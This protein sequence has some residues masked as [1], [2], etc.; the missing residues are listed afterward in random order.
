MKEE[1]R[2]E[3]SA[4]AVFP[5]RMKILPNCI[6]NKRDPIVVGI[7]IIE[8]TARI[9]TPICVPS[10]GKITI[11]KIASMEVDH[12]AV[13]KAEKGKSVAMKIAP[14][15]ADE[16]QRAIGRHFDH[17]DE[18]VSNIS[19]RSIDLLK[20]HFRDEMTKDDWQLVIKLKKLLN[21]D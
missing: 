14:S 15:N 10:K 6:F 11:G 8:G 18:L 7:E 1:R 9:G 19:R 4:E 3:S 5:L 21:V 17:T 2:A 13:E 12:K 20:E 16:G